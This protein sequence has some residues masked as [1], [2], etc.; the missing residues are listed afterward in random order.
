MRDRSVPSSALLTTGDLARIF[1]RT[2]RGARWIA[3]QENLACERLQNGRLLFKPADVQRVAERRMDARLKRVTALRP[4]MRW[5][6][7]EPRQIALFGKNATLPEGEV[8][9]AK[10][11]GK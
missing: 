3:D 6:H 11:G 2:P 9:R 10:F 5:V 8:H 4:K 7:G 1:E